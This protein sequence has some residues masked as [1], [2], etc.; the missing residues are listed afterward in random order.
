[1]LQEVGPRRFRDAESASPPTTHLFL[2]AVGAGGNE[3]ST[4]MVDITAMDQNCPRSPGRD[5]VLS[6]RGG[7]GE[8]RCWGRSYSMV[9]R[10]GRT[11]LRL[12]LD[13]V[14]ARGSSWGLGCAGVGHS[15]GRRRSAESRLFPNGSAARRC[16]CAYATGML[17]RICFTPGDNARCE[18]RRQPIP[19]KLRPDASG[20]PEAGSG[21]ARFASGCSQCI[22]RGISL[23]H[24]K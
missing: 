2:L 18:F 1:M 14:G 17:W 20:A 12:S 7:T 13:P 9:P 23:F 22:G 4:S 5:P 3:H 11:G 16:T 8:V 15:G 10:C 21:G 24:R 6:I 19:N